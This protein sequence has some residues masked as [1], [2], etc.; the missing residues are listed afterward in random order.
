EKVHTAFVSL[1]SQSL[2]ILSNQKTGALI[3]IEGTIKLNEFIK[4]GIVLDAKYS[5]EL[6]ETIFNK[7]TVLHDGA[8]IIRKEKIMAAHVF[9][10][11]IFSSEQ[12]N[13]TRHAAGLAISQERDCI[14]L[15]VSEETGTISYA[16][17]GI[18]TSIPNNYIEE[19]LREILA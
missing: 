13:G 15:M 2:L 4:N 3:V 19:V 16:Q 8:V 11:A 10:P 12:I 6:I 14:A 18:I 17:D 9:L 5:Q 7:N 1:L